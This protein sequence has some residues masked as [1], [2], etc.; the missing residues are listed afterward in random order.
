[1]RRALLIL[2][3]CA[4]CNSEPTATLAE[5]GEIGVSISMFESVT[6]AQTIELGFSIHI[7][8]DRSDC[9]SLIGTLALGVNDQPLALSTFDPGGDDTSICYGPRATAYARRADIPGPE[10]VITIDDGST[11][12]RAATTDLRPIQTVTVIEPADGVFVPAAKV[13]LQWGPDDLAVADTDS[14]RLL[15]T[16]EN[17]T[18]RVYPGDVLADGNEIR[19][20]MPEDSSGTGPASLTVD[21]AR[22]PGFHASS[23]DGAISCAFRLTSVA[24]T[25][26]VLGE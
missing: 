16:D 5:L 15:F 6:E 4:A 24:T 11:T 22:W 20:S 21:G 10:L 26:V 13:R 2:G 25:S 12:I 14:L 3:A 9:P 23:C 8:N 17:G 1:M 7:F 18:D 19:F